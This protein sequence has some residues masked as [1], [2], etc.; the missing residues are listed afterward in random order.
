MHTN[1][2]LPTEDSS[3]DYNPLLT[4]LFKVKTSYIWGN[5]CS[6]IY[7]I[8]EA[9]SFYELCFLLAFYVARFLS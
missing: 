7:I 4:C 6:I 8:P 5:M 9:H 3:P 1:L 2:T